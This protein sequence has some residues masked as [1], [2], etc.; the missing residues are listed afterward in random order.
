L[1]Q[2]SG[3]KIRVLWPG[4]TRAAHYK[5]AIDD[6]STRIRKLLPFEI[7]ETRE[8]ALRDK[9]RQARISE[10]SRD[11][12]ARIRP[13]IAVYFDAD[14]KPISSEELAQWLQNHSCQADFILGGPEGCLIPEKATVFS[15]GR[16][17]LP[18]ELARVVLLE[19][20]YRSLTILRKIPYHK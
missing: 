16:I 20:I 2:P 14:G 1:R 13:S 18:H 3:V 17:T 4:R 5:S 12:Q 15:F 7:V 9:Q 19:Q 6:Y 10:E 11:L 8:R